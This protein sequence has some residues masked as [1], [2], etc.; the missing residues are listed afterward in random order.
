MNLL[1]E[2][3]LRCIEVGGEFP[4]TK[5]DFKFHKEVLTQSQNKFALFQSEYFTDELIRELKKICDIDSK[6]MHALRKDSDELNIRS[7][8][9]AQIPPQ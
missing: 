8:I 3:Y 5:L 6:N 4:T 1:C 2:A 7:E 9:L